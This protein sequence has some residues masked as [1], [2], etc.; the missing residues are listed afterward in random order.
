MERLV[1]ACRWGRRGEE[2]KLGGGSAAADGRKAYERPDV[3]RVS[4][5]EVVEKR[6]G[7]EEEQKRRG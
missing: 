5:R 3:R 1:E 7:E 2:E 6:K 4:V